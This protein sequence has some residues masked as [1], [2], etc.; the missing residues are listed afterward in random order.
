[1]RLDRRLMTRFGGV[2]AW[3]V[4][5]VSALPAQ[6][7][8][9]GIDGNARAVLQQ[10]AV[11]YRGAKGW[12][13][14]GEL[15]RRA[16]QGEKVAEAR[17]TLQLA[18]ERPNKLSV[19]FDGVGL[20]CD[21]KTFV[22][23][24]DALR[25][26]RSQ[27]APAEISLADVMVSP[28]GSV[29]LGAPGESPITLLLTLLLSDD[30][31]GTL[32]EG[33]TALRLEKGKDDSEQVLVIERA[34]RAELRLTVE[35]A[36]PRVKRMEARFGSGQLKDVAAG[37]PALEELGW[38]WEG[39]LVPGDVQTFTYVP[40]AGYSEVVVAKA[41]A[42][43]EKERHPLVGQPAP[44]F[45]FEMIEGPGKARKV[46]RADFV[47]KVV[48]LDFWATWCPP[49]REE[50]PEIQALVERLEKQH[51]GK[52]VV[53]ALSQDRAPE[54]SSPVRELVEKSL[55]EMSVV[56]GSKSVGRVGLDSEQVVGDACGVEG[57]PMVVVIDG[58][59]VVQSV[60]IG[61]EEGIGDILANEIEALLAGKSLIEG[62]AAK[63]D[64]GAR[65]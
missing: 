31:A 65:R 24:S 40:A 17:E 48:V 57:I 36:R 27:P 35:K 59:G 56:L 22:T 25:K 47:G 53:V 54:D 52:V 12:H 16:R 6:E 42:P 23:V 11:K 50:L 15:I 9:T 19:A 62:P 14:K 5:V 43:A 4:L 30:A 20:V 58:Q 21:G 29:L 28:L 8:Q 34:P 46:T 38:A 45:A 61:Y 39:E 49:C 13:E 7:A 33:A 37:V 55:K 26:Y 10:L 60:Q 51:A 18:F 32:L 2:L 3:G 41:K 63:P 1:M 44:E 64:R